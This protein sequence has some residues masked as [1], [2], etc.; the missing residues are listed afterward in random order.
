VANSLAGATQD[1]VRRHNLG[2]LLQLLHVHGATSRSDLTALTGLN[3]S[4]VGALTTE[5]A[6]AGLVSEQA[7]VGRGGA[8]RPSIMVRPQ[9]QRVHVLA[10]DVGVDHIIAARVGLGGEVLDRRELRQSRGDYQMP[11]ILRHVEQLGRSVLA[12]APSD[13]VCVGIGA[14]V[15]GVVSHADGLVRFAPNLGWVDVPFGAQIA[16]RLSTSLPVVVG[17]DAD[18][19]A[20]SEHVRGAA[21]GSDNVIYLSGE[22]GVGG[23]I[24]LDGR[25]MSGAGGYGG[26]VGHMAVNPRGRLCRCGARGCWE[27]EV[28]EEAA[29]LAAGRPDSTIEA[30]IALAAAGDKQAKAGLRRVGGWLGIGVANLVNLFNPEVVVFG[31]V[32]RQLFPATESQVRA[33]LG[34]A[35]AAPREQVRLAVPALGADSTLL[36]AAE[37][38][39][40]PLLDDPLGAL[41]HGAVRLRA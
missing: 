35:L 33:A 22:V 20:I 13:S 25:A 34:T 40:G 8:G 24:I 19:G 38:A 30:V 36:G 16:D 10:L 23:G 39:F 7:P 17:N 37:S 3:R 14:G 21:K 11:K 5:L 28:G 1:E 12:G 6:E 15:C 32:L 4:T 26:E 18:L 27:T 9:T 29:L 41:V 31:G 2:N